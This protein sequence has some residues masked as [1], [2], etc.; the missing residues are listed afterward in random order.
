MEVIMLEHLIESE[1]KKRITIYN[2][3]S[4]AVVAGSRHRL[5]RALRR[6]KRFD[7]DLFDRSFC[8]AV[9][10]GWPMRKRPNGSYR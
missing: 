8:H 4:A 3:V 9:Y 7:R 5:A 10:V 1:A 2:E 6:A